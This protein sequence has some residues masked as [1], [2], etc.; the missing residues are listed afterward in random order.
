MENDTL[1]K[2]KIKAYC[3]KAERCHHDVR[4][5][6]FLWKVPAE[7]HGE[8]IADLITQNLLNEERYALAFVHDHHT[9][10]RWGKEKIRQGLK[11]KQVSSFLIEF[12]LKSVQFESEEENLRTCAEKK[13]TS[14]KDENQHKRRAKLIRYL[15]GRGFDMEAIQKAV[16]RVTGDAEFE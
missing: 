9:F 15:Y 1:L 4:N 11:K 14:L 8:I 5:K 10:R 6:L 12:A 16:R 2:A 3:D 13:W 7:R